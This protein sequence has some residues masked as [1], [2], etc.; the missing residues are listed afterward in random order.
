MGKI[1]LIAETA[2]HHDGD[3]AFMERLVNEILNESKLD[4]LK[5]HLTL[6][7]DEY[8][9]PS[10]SIYDGFKTKLFSKKQW[11]TLFSDVHKSK[12]EL[13]LLY[14]DTKAIEFGEKFDPQYV[15]IHSAC[16][17]DIYLLDTLK[18]NISSNTRIVFGIG[19]STLYEI[20]NAINRIQHE[21]LILMFGF[22]N[23]PTRYEDINFKKM[24]RIM[25]LF[26]EFSFGYADHTAWD[27]PNNI[28]ITIMGVALGVDYVEKHVTNVY[29]EKRVDWNSAVSIEMFNEISK[30]LK[31]LNKCRGNGLIKLNEGEEKYSLY[32]PMKKAAVLKVAVKK[33]DI[34]ANDKIE[35]KRTGE[36]TDLSQIEVINRFGYVILEDLRVGDL[37]FSRHLKK[38]K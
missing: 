37:L 1:K 20:E 36:T 19:G 18:N 4:V 32:G 28:L 29:G 10:H 14:N 27:E 34:L 6:D 25:N 13:M 33:G 22:Q 26:P 16:L 31:I 9:H 21:N 3:F 30:K 5:M 12:K 35:F 17:N 11:S 15:E 23:F 7:F 2:W 38:E 24:Q 8:I